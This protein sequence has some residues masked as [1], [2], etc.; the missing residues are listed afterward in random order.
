MSIDVDYYNLEDLL[1]Q[2]ERLV[3]GCGAALH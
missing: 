1:G 2:E 3:A